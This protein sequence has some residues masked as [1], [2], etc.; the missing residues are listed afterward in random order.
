[1]SRTPDDIEDELLVL[2]CQTG[3][4]EALKTL[5]GRWQTRL[6][7]LAYRLT[8][9]REAARD[10]V[11]EAWLS[12]I[13]GV[14]RLD[15]PARFRSWAYRIVRNKCADWVRRRGVQRVA[16]E[17]LRTVAPPESA[18]PPASSDSSEE[19]ERL[20]EALANLP[21]EQRAI[22]S[23]CYLD[24]M[25]VAEIAKVFDIAVGTVKSR[26]FHARSRLRKALERMKT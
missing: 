7:R 9:E 6:G 5:I 26:L 14:A 4:A 24:G 15:D 25:S 8:G 2:Q 1:M 23:L 20:R 19:M 16:D 12:I 22:L 13:R 17:E 10:S 21:D 11:Q 18:D 3:D